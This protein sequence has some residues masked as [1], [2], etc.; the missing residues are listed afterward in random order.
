MRMT[1]SNLK[2]YLHVLPTICLGVILFFGNLP[3]A[4]PT[5]TN[6][7]KHIIVII[8]ENHTYDNYFGTYPNANGLN[9]NV[10]LPI[11]PNSDKKVYPFHI[12]NSTPTIDLTHNREPAL[13]A[14]NNGKMDGFVY[15]EK[16]DLTMGYFDNRDI[17]NYWNYASKFV[18]A[19]NFFTSV[20]GP[21]LPNHMFL[22]A[23]Q[24][25]GIVDNV[26]NITLD[27]P[28]IMDELDSHDLS[29]KYYGVNDVFHY[30]NPLPAFQSFKNNSTR[31]SNCL[32]TNQ[33]FTDVSEGK[34]A[35]VVWIRN[36]SLSEHPPQNVTLGQNFVVSIINEVMNSSFWSSSAI[37]IVWDDYGGW[38]DHVPPPQ[39]D[40]IGY[41]LRSP[42]LVI[43]PYAKSGFVDHELNDL[44]SLLKFIETTFSLAPLA[45]R[46]A[47]ANNLM[48]A[49]DFSQPPRETLI[50]PGQY[51]PDSYPLRLQSDENKDLNW[52]SKLQ[53][54]ILGIATVSLISLLAG[55]YIKKHK[56]AKLPIQILNSYTKCALNLSFNKRHM[57]LNISFK[58]SLLLP[59]SRIAKT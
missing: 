40:K 57:Y 27:F 20:M 30:A 41:G 51:V 32:P 48:E 17:P 45:E 15:A 23:G 54:V 52:L 50:L 14:F 47:E 35:D 2:K 19:D 1:H 11:E 9:P 7:I 21:S 12:E 56:N 8:Q 13:E 39:V 53:Y 16:S 4:S 29:W 59:F 22:F 31:F 18:L 28:C 42:L 3:T 25:G 37:F 44:T 10:G 34:L 43:S 24:S 5:Q 26:D 6:P 46:D 58:P 55:L 49:F 38:Y 33:F 36:E